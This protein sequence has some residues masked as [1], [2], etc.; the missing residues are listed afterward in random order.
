MTE[1][2]FKKYHKRILLM[3]I[4]SYF[5]EIRP[6]SIQTRKQKQFVYDFERCHW[7]A[8]QVYSNEDVGVALEKIDPDLETHMDSFSYASSFS[9]LPL[10]FSRSMVDVNAASKKSPRSLKKVLSKKSLESEA[11]LE[12]A[13]R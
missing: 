6:G 2:N 4:F 11:S 8:L 13:K 7:E 3:I 1:L 5:M 12:T 9:T 10:P